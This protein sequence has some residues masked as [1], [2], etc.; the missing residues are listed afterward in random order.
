MN[1]KTYLLTTKTTPNALAVKAG[2]CPHIIH[3]KLKQQTVGDVPKAVK[4]AQKI[5]A[6]TGGQVS[7]LEFLGLTPCSC[8]TL[9]QAIERLGGES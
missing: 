5:E 9:Q 2:V 4:T 6:A 3:R 7:A 8:V 1:L